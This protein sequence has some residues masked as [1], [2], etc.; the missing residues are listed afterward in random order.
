MAID[1]RQL[2]PGELARLLNSTP[3]GEVISERQL[4]RHRTRAGFRV[5]ADGDAGK[6]DLFRYVAWLIGESF[7]VGMNQRAEDGRRV[8]LADAVVGMLLGVALVGAVFY[9][10]LH[11]YDAVTLTGSGFKADASRFADVTVYFV[12]ALL[13][14][15]ALAAP[16]PSR[17]KPS[18]PLAPCRISDPD[19]LV[20][21]EARCGSLEVPEDPDAP[22]GPRIRLALA[23][24]PAVATR[25]KPDPLVL[26]AGGP[27]QGTIEG[28][29]PVLSAF[30]RHRPTL[31]LEVSSGLSAGLLAAY[32]RGEYD[33][34]LVKQRE[35]QARLSWPER[36]VWL[37]SRA[38]PALARDPLPLAVFPV[39]GLYRE[40][41]FQALDARRT[42]WRI[43]YCSASLASLQAAVADGLG[44][45]LLPERAIRA[46][47]R[48]LEGKHGLPPV[49]PV[50]GARIRF[51]RRRRSSGSSPTRSG[52][53]TSAM[54]AA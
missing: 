22:E 44:I 39:G 35:T 10:V 3:L 21:T 51:H 5:A 32:E 18:I 13:L 36:L 7:A 45:S 50:S 14:F 54:K 9:W 16:G 46:G 49:R 19:G 26:I 8:R 41:M 40:E 38:H 42:R 12:I 4:H 48:V 43:G 31:R 29:A 28:F 34:V 17:A 52:A 2:K 30:A 53:S 23:V 33:V 27:G 47:H 37:D 1:P 15:A 24:V 11:R 25:A 20:S 6:V